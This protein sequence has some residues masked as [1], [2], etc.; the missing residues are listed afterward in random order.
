MVKAACKSRMQSMRTPPFY[1][2]PTRVYCTAIRARTHWKERL[3]L[4]TNDGDL[5]HGLC[6]YHSHDARICACA[7]QAITR[8]F[9]HRA[10]CANAG[11]PARGRA[12]NRSLFGAKRWE[13]HRRIRARDRAPS[14]EAR[15]VVSA[16]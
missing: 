6:P 9:P 10:R 3:G 1:G 7:E 15:L 2:G 13:I 5:S 11:T 14:D 12:R 8:L 4:R 16:R